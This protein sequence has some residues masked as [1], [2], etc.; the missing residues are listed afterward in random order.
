M[1][2]KNSILKK[3]ITAFAGKRIMII[4]DAMID[5]YWIGKANRISPEAPVPILSVSDKEYK[6]GGAANVALNIKALGAVPYLYTI[7][8]ND[9]AGNQLKA[10][11]Q[12]QK[13]FDKGCISIDGR[14]TTVK[15]R[16]LSQS[17]HMLRIDEE[18]T[19]DLI[20]KQQTLLA[21]TIVKAI[22]KIKPE[23]IIIED[24]DKGMLSKLVIEAIIEKANKLEIPVAVDPKHKNFWLYKNV[25]LFKPN[26]R[27]V[28]EGLSKQID[29]TNITSLTVADNTMR[30]QLNHQVSL[31]TLS[32]HGAFVGTDK[33]HHK[34]EAHVRNIADVSGAGDTVISVAALCLACKTNVLQMAE[35]A[36]LAGGLVC[37][38]RGVVAIT[39]Q[40]LMDEC[41]K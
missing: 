40:Q 1:I 29:P 3:T 37:E 23:A 24:Y 9:N 2:T 25:T 28:S 32:E 21:D 17:S 8:G 36:N 30:K 35:L 7:I 5:A 6:L 22:A 27:E 12:Q 19:D 16:I 34:I 14:V 18:Q 26:L 4:G 33:A 15:T 31:I 10:L 11:L 13:M 38:K 20:G 39:A 41:V